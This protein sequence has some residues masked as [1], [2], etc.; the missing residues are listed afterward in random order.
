MTGPEGNTY[1]ANPQECCDCNETYDCCGRCNGG[2]GDEDGEYGNCSSCTS[3]SIVKS[4]GGN[5]IPKSTRVLQIL[6]ILINMETY[7]GK[8]MIS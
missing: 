4:S 6:Y 3:V 7:L 2:A 5:N 1:T 8:L